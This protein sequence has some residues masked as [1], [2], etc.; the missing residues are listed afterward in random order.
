MTYR[1]V[2]LGLGGLVL[3]GLFILAAA[4]FPPALPMLI[5]VVALLVLIGGGNLLSA[6]RTPSRTAAP[7]GGAGVPGGSSDDPHQ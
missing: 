6:N 2:A 7:R 3:V 5:T 1:L 4:G